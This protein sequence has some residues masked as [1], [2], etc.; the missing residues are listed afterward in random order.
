P[1]NGFTARVVNEEDSVL[2]EFMFSVPK[3]SLFDNFTGGG[4]VKEYEGERI[5]LVAGYHG[6]AEAVIILNPDKEE[7][8]R[9][10]VSAFKSLEE[11]REE[12]ARFKREGIMPWY[13][14]LVPITIIAAG[15]AYAY[16]RKTSAGQE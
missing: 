3:A 2:D 13:Y 7:V 16:H 8:L 6:N 9:I 12:K 10:D 15:I 5:T 11:Q 4:G 1:K 14:L